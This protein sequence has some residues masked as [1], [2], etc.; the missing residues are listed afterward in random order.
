MCGVGPG[1]FTGLRAGMA[2]AAA[3]GHALDRPVYPVCTL[4]AIAAAVDPGGR[5]SW[6]PTRAARRSTGPPTTQHGTRIAGP[7]VDQ[8]DALDH[9]RRSPRIAGNGAPVHL[10]LPHT[11]ASYPTPPDWCARAD[12]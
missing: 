11:G 5:C 12:V 3:L 4:D 2:T 10:G 6:P 1:P 9:E 8:P 7:S